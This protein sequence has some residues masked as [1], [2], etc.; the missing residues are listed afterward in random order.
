MRSKTAQVVLIENSVPPRPQQ[1]DL[2]VPR[3][4]D[5]DR[6]PHKEVGKIVKASPLLRPRPNSGPVPF[7]LPPI[8][9]TEQPIVIE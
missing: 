8:A 6:V 9:E 2:I 1:H 7:S 5:A 3:G 4:R